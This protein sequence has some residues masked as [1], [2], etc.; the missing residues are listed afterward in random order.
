MAEY[1]LQ[2]L[3]TQLGIVFSWGFHFPTRLPDNKGLA[4]RVNGFKYQGRVAV[5]YDEGKDLFDVIVGDKRITDVYLENLV[6]VIDHAVERTD[7]YE[8]RVKECYN[9]H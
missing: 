3:K 5:E 6:D 1:I 9:I 8:Q 7:N 4:F 2:I